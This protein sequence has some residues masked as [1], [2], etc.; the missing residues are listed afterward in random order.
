MIRE[1][2]AYGDTKSN[3]CLAVSAGR[4][5]W[6]RLPLYADGSLFGTIAGRV[7]DESGA[8]LPGVTVE[9]ESAD[10]GFQRTATTD[11]AGSFNFAL[12]PPGL[13]TVRA[14]A[15]GFDDRRRRPT[16]S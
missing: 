14:S 1:R 5:S 6:R 2:G 7:R 8:A 12:L 10:K 16:T 11:A 9:V 3:R 15:P 4:T 13:Y